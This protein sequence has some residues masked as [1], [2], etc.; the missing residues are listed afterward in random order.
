MKRISIIAAAIATTSTT[1]GAVLVSHAQTGVLHRH[2]TASAVVAGV[3]AH[4]AAKKGA[5][6]RAASGK[7][8]NFAERHPVLSGVAAGAATHHILKKH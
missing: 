1:F 5:Q 2:P 3:A 6:G 4:H 7:K 8:P